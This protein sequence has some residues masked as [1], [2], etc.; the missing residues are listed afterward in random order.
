MKR[1]AELDAAALDA[2][3]AAAYAA[4]AGGPRGAVRGPLAVWLHRPGLANRAQALG[5]Y[6]RYETCLPARL[7]ELAIVLTGHIWQSQYEWDAHVP[8]AL[9]AGVAPAIIDA[10][11]EG[12]SP[13]FSQTDEAAVYEFVTALH[14]DRSVP[15][16]LYERTVRVLGQ[17]AV[18]DLVGIAGYYTLISMTINVFGIESPQDCAKTPEPTEKSE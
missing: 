7:S 16:S 10:L 14:R 9:K 4:I 1:I 2:E 18:V 13:R 12:E 8:L 15:D 6:C 11:A 3:Q 17:D 5:Q